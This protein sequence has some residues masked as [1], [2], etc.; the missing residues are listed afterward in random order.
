MT[1]IG[2]AL[3]RVNCENVGKRTQFGAGFRPICIRRSG[4]LFREISLFLLGLTKKHSIS[5]MVYFHHGLLAGPS[6]FDDGDKVGNLEGCTTDKSAINVR[7]AHQRLG[8]CRLD[9][10]PVLQ[11]NARASSAKSVT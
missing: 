2:G 6:G 7:L 10:A 5:L 9:R 4:I 1:S 8:I 11:A 3:F